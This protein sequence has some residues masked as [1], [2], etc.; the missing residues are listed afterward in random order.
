MNFISVL[1]RPKHYYKPAQKILLSLVALMT[2]HCT[3]SNWS[4][5]IAS[6]R[7][8][9]PHRAMSGFTVAPGAPTGS[10]CHRI[11]LLFILKAHTLF[12]CESAVSHTVFIYLCAQ[13]NLDM[14]T[15]SSTKWVKCKNARR[16]KYSILLRHLSTETN[17]TFE[18]R[19]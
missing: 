1:A 14:L 11:V 18:P 10:M 16:P 12:F 3:I 13:S 2:W 5:P 4:V 15:S 7:Q 19:F 8:S 9:C 6:R 17:P